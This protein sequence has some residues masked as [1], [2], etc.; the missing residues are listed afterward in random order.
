[1]V[2][3]FSWWYIV[4][5]VALLCAIGCLVSFFVMNKKD[6]KLIKEF[7]ATQTKE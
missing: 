7:K 2:F 3:V 4:A 5:I 6:E 1:M